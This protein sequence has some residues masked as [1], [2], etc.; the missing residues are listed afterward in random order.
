MKEGR[1]PGWVVGV[2]ALA[3]DPKIIGLVLAAFGLGGGGGWV[4]A[5]AGGMTPVQVDSI[6]R[7]ADKPQIEKLNRMDTAM[8]RIYFRQDVQMS[9][10]E[11]RRAD[12]L[13]RA[14]LKNINYGGSP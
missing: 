8:M 9:E 5:D 12:S 3:A 7:A 2:R 14:A 10:D 13:M 6:A 4:M 11:K 1:L